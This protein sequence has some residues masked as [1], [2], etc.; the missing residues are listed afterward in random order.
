MLDLRILTKEN[1]S[2]LD[3]MRNLELMKKR[4][5]QESMHGCDV[6]LRDIQRSERLNTQIQQLAKE[7][8]QKKLFSEED[9][10]SLPTH[11]SVDK[12]STNI[13]SPNFWQRAND[14]DQTTDGFKL[15]ADLQSKFD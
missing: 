9:K 1:A 13:I 14:Y 10:G 7:W 15:T 12:I 8:K 4:F 2:Y 11:L 6:M 3:E 5:G